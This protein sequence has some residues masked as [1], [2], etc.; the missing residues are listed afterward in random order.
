M[1]SKTLLGTRCQ[2]SMPESRVSY[3]A[4]PV[5][6]GVQS[7]ASNSFRLRSCPDPE[8][9]FPYP[10]LVL[11]PTRIRIHNTAIKYKMSPINER[12]PCLL[13]RSTCRTWSSIFYFK[14]IS[15]PELPWSSILFPYPDPAKSFGSGR[16]RSCPDPE[17]C[18]PH[19]DPAKSF[20]SERILIHNTA[21]K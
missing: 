10:D 1:K 14:F 6:H 3:L 12:K 17:W 19:P 15:A 8:W 13:P 7:F 20:G 16:L 11:D 9:F 4:R 5:E 18:F 21:I 2:E